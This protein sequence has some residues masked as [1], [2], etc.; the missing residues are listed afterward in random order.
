S[1][2]TT[3]VAPSASSVVAA[4]DIDSPRPLREEVAELER[5][6]NASL[7]ECDAQAAVRAILALEETIQ[8]WAG[9]TDQ[10]D[11]L[12]TARSTLRGAIVCLGEMAV[13]GSR[14]PAT[15]IG[16][17]VDALLAERVRAREAREWAAADAIRDR[18][19]AAGIELHDTPD[20]TTW[21]PR[22]AEA[23]VS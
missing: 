5:V 1:A 12:A 23:P 7:E 3:A 16:P 22:P 9:D 4:V 18:L 19:L 17:F 14:D 20:G 6:F 21:E 10:S 8:A 15:L 2:P 13:E 11:A